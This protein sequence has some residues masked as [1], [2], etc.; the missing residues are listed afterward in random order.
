MQHMSVAL[1]I[2]GATGL[3]KNGVGSCKRVHIFVKIDVAALLG[4][5][6]FSRSVISRRQH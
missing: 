1:L 6:R 2:G 3:D 4:A 5:R